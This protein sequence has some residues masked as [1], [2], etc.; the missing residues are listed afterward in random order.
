MNYEIKIERI[1]DTSHQLCGGYR[2]V[3]ADLGIIV[4]GESEGECVALV[5]EKAAALDWQR[6]RQ[7]DW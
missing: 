6:K 4:G 1:A 2:A 5:L 7:G 3:C